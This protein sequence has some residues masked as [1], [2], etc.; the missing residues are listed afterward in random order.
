M[1]N[2]EREQLWHDRLAEVTEFYNKNGRNPKSTVPEEAPL[3]SWFTMQRVRLRTGTMRADR[4]DLLDQNLPHWRETA[5][6]EDRFTTNLNAYVAFLEKNGVAPVSSSEDENERKLAIWMSNQ[7]AQARRDNAS[8]DAIAALDAKIPGWNDWQRKKQK[9]SDKY[10]S[11]D[12]S[13]EL[14]KE[15]IEN[16]GVKPVFECDSDE[17]R[18][19]AAWLNN[20]RRLYRKGKLNSK[21]LAALDVTIPNWNNISRNDGKWD[22]NLKFIATFVKENEFSPSTASNNEDERKA[23]RWFAEQRRQ[24]ESGELSSERVAKLDAAITNWRT[25]K[26]LTSVS[27]WMSTLESVAE[28]VAN[29]NVFPATTSPDPD[30]RRMGFWVTRNRKYLKDEILAADKIALLDEKIPGWSSSR[31]GRPRR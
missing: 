28:Y 5:S 22:K 19:L 7:K 17:E 8:P 1:E 14:L 31:I 2:A 15:F 3:A 27:S 21:R 24:D 4:A 10:P 12:K 25:V 18:R 26:A 30:V 13:L 6:R 29:N 11:W 23:A 20:Q 9:R 16:N